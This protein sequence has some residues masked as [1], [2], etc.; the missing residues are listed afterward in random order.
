MVDVR[1]FYTQIALY[2]V[3]SGYLSSKKLDKNPTILSKKAK[4]IFTPFLTVRMYRYIFLKFSK[5]VLNFFSSNVIVSL[6]LYEEVLNGKKSI[7]INF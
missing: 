2:F 3:T 1:K 7:E 4:S 6:F 5:L